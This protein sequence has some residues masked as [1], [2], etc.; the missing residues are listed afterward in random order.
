MK[1]I[2][3]SLMRKAVMYLAALVV[4]ATAVFLATYLL[5][6]HPSLEA[7]LE[8]LTAP[9]TA[10]DPARSKGIPSLQPAA[11]PAEV[12]V[13]QMDPGGEPLGAG[14]LVS[15][16]PLEPAGM[17]I[18][19]DVPALAPVPGYDAPSF[20]GGLAAFLSR[21]PGGLRVGL[22][23]LAGAAGQCGSTDALLGFGQSGGGEHATALD[24]ASGLGRGPRNPARAVAAAAD[25][26]SSVAGEHCI[27][28]VAGGEEGCNA[29]LCG[30]A[31]PPG[32]PVQRIH[33]L[34]LAP[35]LQPGTDP[36]ML[37][38]GSVGMLQPVFEPDWAAPY[39]CLADRSGGTVASVSSPLEFEAALRRIAGTLESAVVVRGFHYTGQEIRGISPGG[40]AG[41]GVTLRPGANTGA[42]ARVFESDLFPTAFAV[43]R[44]VHVL[45]ARYGGQERT[46]AVAV[47]AGER[48]EVRVTFATGELF[49][50]ALDAAGGEIVGDSAGFRCAWGADVFPGGGEE[51]RPVA[52]T[53]SF[54]ARLELPPGSYVVRARWKGIERIIEEV[55]VEAAAS[56]VRAVSFGTAD[57]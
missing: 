45:K 26:L 44:G 2:D 47:A 31:L 49:L 15:R 19:T 9:R 54:P 35:R 10:P 25:D 13:A 56:S 38:A 3:A 8:R 32:G 11:A 50:Q 1:F 46:A 41:W 22:R 5:G 51:S 36:G 29:D 18:I 20:A 6:R 37:D 43:S 53:C 33:V 24:A 48:A 14:I 16:S 21:P 27:V 34:L 28:I 4:A 30:A 42:E 39:R 12:P 52:S 57:N 55:T 17:V 7:E 23:A 40:D